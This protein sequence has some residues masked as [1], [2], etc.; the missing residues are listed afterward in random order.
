MDSV[1]CFLD[2][3]WGPSILVVDLFLAGLLLLLQI[4]LPPPFLSSECCFFL[5]DTKCSIALTIEAVSEEGRANRG[6]ASRVRAL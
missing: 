3:V 4:A 2:L 6:V 5:S 1:A